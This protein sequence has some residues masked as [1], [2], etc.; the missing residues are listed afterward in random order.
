MTAGKEEHSYLF[1]YKQLLIVIKNTELG[2]EEALSEYLMSSVGLVFQNRDLY[3]VTF[4]SVYLGKKEG[5]VRK[6]YETD[7]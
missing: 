1:P 4:I 3:F 5:E 2:T 6:H 7:R